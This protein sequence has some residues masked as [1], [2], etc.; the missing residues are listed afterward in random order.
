MQIVNN[1]KSVEPKIFGVRIRNHGPGAY[2]LAFRHSGDFK[3]DD[4]DEL[5]F[6]VVSTKLI[7]KV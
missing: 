4:F 5:D 7:K 2:A 6:E 1:E 3:L